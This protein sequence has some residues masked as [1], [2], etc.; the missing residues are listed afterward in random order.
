MQVPRHE[1]SLQLP[2]FSTI[3]EPPD[4]RKTKRGTGW[5][6]T[7]GGGWKEATMAKKQQNS[8][9][10]GAVPTRTDT[11]LLQSEERFRNSGARAATTF[12]VSRA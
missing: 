9:P 1:Q 5:V 2:I 3:L 11:R 6:R 4:D 10:I 8:R 7:A 12:Y